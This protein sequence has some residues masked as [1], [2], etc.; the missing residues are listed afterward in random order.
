MF[1]YLDSGGFA[2]PEYF[3]DYSG[4]VV[5]RSLNPN[6]LAENAPTSGPPTQTVALAALSV[7]SAPIQNQ[8]RLTYSRDPQNPIG[9]DDG[10][11]VIARD[12]RRN[13]KTA[14][15][16]TV[17]SGEDFFLGFSKNTILL[18]AFAAGFVMYRRGL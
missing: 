2:E 16:N 14:D 1:Q 12:I 5:T 9:F 17:I 11:R 13:I 4:P 8:P 10:P 3:E 7:E 6:G 18:A 15:G